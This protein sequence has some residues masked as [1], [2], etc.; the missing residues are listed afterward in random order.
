MKVVMSCLAAALVVVAGVGCSGDSSSEQP[1]CLC[2]LQ[3]A[4]S[5][6]ELLYYSNPLLAE[7]E[8]MTYVNENRGHFQPNSP[9]IVCMRD[10]GSWLVARELSQYSSQDYDNAY[11]SCLGMGATGVQARQ[12]AGEIQGGTIELLATGQ[13]LLWLADVFPM[14]ASGNWNPYLTLAGSTE[15]RVMAR[16][17]KPIYDQLMQSDP[18]TAQIVNQFLRQFDELAIYRIVY[19]A[20]LHSLAHQ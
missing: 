17:V 11:S 7:A 5:V 19:L 6:G 18:Y 10:L 2:D 1:A 15:S 14:G 4:R 12:V 20:Y 8:V 3:I 16:R 13:E 9:I